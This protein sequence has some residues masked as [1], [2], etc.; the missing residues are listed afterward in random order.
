MYPRKSESAPAFYAFKD[1]VHAH[2]CELNAG[3]TVLEYCLFPPVLV[4]D[5]QMKHVHV[6]ILVEI[7]HIGNPR[8]SGW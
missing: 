1:N 4:Y 8:L 5:G 7:L 2:L 6:Y 3:T